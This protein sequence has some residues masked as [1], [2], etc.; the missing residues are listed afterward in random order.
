MGPHGH[1]ILVQVLHHQLAQPLAALDSRLAVPAAIQS[2]R[3]VDLLVDARGVAVDGK[4][5]VGTAIGCKRHNL[6]QVQVVLGR[7]GRA[8]DG[9]LIALIREDFL[10]CQS[11]GQVGVGFIVV[12]RVLCTNHPRGHVA[13]IAVVPSMTGIDKHA[14]HVPAAH[15]VF[16]LFGLTLARSG[17]HGQCRRDVK[18]Q[19]LDLAVI[20]DTI[21]DLVASHH[22]LHG[23]L[24]LGCDGL[25]GFAVDADEPDARPAQA[26]VAHVAHRDDVVIVVPARHEELAQVGNNGAIEVTHVQP[27]GRGLKQHTGAI[28]RKRRPQVAV[29]VLDGLQSTRGA[30][31]IDQVEHG[32]ARVAIGTHLLGAAIDLA[33]AIDYHSTGGMQRLHAP[34]L[35]L[36]ND[37]VLARGRVIAAARAVEKA[38]L[39]ALLGDIV[40]LVVGAQDGV[41]ARIARRGHRGHGARCEILQQQAGR[42]GRRVEQPLPI[43]TQLREKATTVNQRPGA[44]LPHASG[45]AIEHTQARQQQE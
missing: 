42:L 25:H 39:L 44:A 2:Q 12:Q 11:F 7:V 31:L 8:R 28:G 1:L 13:V 41:K 23:A 21:D 43:G 22:G 16:H 27:P 33:L 26:D 30:L 5:D 38:V 9:S 3:E 32:A 20:D 14:G 4:E 10:Q 45:A 40:H 15:G 6:K 24:V 36:E 37:L 17:R 19:L 18:G 34:V 29:T 35:G